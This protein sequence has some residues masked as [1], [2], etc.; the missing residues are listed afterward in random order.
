MTEAEFRA[1]LSALGLQLDT[2]AFAAAW[3]GAQQLRGE[4]ERVQAWLS[5]QT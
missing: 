3:A 5:S 1:K 2:V 4:V